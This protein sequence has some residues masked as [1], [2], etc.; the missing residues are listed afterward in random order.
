MSD[1]RVLLDKD[2]ETHIARLTLNNPERKNCYDPEMRRAIRAAMDD[3]ATD[4][5]I[6]V[7]RSTRAVSR[8]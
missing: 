1:T 3:V 7:L 6:K 4:D 5:D 2:R 8:T